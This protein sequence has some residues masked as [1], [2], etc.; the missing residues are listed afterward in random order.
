MTNTQ[1]KKIIRFSPK[2][3]SYRYATN[4]STYFIR[5]KSK[6]RIYSCNIFQFSFANLLKSVDLP[7]ITDT[8]TLTLFV[9]FCLKRPSLICLFILFF[10]CCSLSLSLSLFKSY[11]LIALNAN[12]WTLSQLSI[13]H[14]FFYSSI[15]LISNY[16]SINPSVYQSINL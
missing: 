16:L 6:H 1:V 8:H 13:S 9:L 4:S 12:I 15:Y 14:K 3:T 10:I 2:I 5:I 11:P 7:Q